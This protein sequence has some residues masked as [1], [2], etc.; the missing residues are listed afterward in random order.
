MKLLA[1]LRHALISC[2]R[3]IFE[4][5]PLDETFVDVREW[6]FK[7]SGRPILRHQKNTIAKIL[8][9]I[10]GYYLMQVSVLGSK[11]L[12]K[13]SPIRY[14]FIVVPVDSF[15]N[16]SKKVP[17]NVVVCDFQELGIETDSVDVVLLHHALDFSPNPHQL[18]RES[19][20]ITMPNGL[21]II[22]GFNRWSFSSITRY[23][24]CFFN[25]SHFYRHHRFGVQRL[26]DWCKVLELDA[27]HIEYGYHCPLYKKQFSKKLDAILSY[28]LPMFG[29]YYV[30]IARKNVNAM[31]KVNMK[32]RKKSVLPQWG[33]R[34]LNKSAP[35]KNIAIEI[36]L[37]KNEKC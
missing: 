18:L 4:I 19:A 30:L 21:V 16:D 37:E 8:P 28:C 10:F 20:R 29:Q 25:R 11:K 9:D 14:P 7:N 1:N 3:N 24:S 36:P 27:V 15:L 6:F 2:F 34:A 32:W 23:F 22:V 17:G 12:Y 35:V 5:R 31:N 26:K 33:E 13:S